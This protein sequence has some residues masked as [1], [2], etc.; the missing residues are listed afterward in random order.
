MT[1]YCKY[2]VVIVLS[3]V[4]W[5]LKKKKMKGLLVNPGCLD[6]SLAVA[7]CSNTDWSQFFNGSFMLLL[8]MSFWDYLGKESDA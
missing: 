2:L 7:C 6:K 5:P 3:T 1:Q 8:T 4:I